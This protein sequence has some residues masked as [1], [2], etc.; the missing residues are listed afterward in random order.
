MGEER[1]VER[2]YLSHD[3][4]NF[5]TRGSVHCGE[6]FDVLQEKKKRNLMP[7]CPFVPIAAGLS[8]LITGSGRE[9]IDHP[10]VL[11]RCFMHHFLFAPPPPSLSLVL[12][13]LL[14]HGGSGV[15]GNTKCR[16]F[17]RDCEIASC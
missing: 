11:Q 15:T 9:R 3:I 7:C 16:I 4:I 6:S 12:L 10:S 13:K 14:L 8:F 2:L 5:I 17:P 1:P